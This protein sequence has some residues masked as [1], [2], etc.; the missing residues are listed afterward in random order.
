MTITLPWRGS[1]TRR[2]V[3]RLADLERQLAAAQAD[4]ASLLTWRAKA[5]DIV[6][7]LE[8]RYKQTYKAWEAEAALRAETE[9]VAGCTQSDLQEV[10]AD[11]DRLQAEVT[12]LR[13][14]L[15][16]RNAIS[17][18]IGERDI[19]PGDHPTEPAGIDVRSLRERFETGRVVSLHH[20]PHAAIDP[21]HFPVLAVRLVKGVS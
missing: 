11:R 15:A 6:E 17:T 4:N 7:E 8:D 18:A 20:S 12:A 1:G 2:A 21:A 5:L 16:N 19:D 14:Q 10:T 9:S 3:D 13:A